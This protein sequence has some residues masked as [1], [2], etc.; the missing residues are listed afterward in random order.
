MGTELI[1]SAREHYVGRADFD[2]AGQEPFEV[3]KQSRA[4]DTKSTPRS[5]EDPARWQAG[6]DREGKA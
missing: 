4:S 5:I 1:R 6:P 2:M 3:L